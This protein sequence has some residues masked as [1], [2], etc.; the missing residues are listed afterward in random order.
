[1]RFELS[2]RTL[3]FLLT[4]LAVLDGGNVARSAEEEFNP[5]RAKKTNDEIL[6]IVFQEPFAEELDPP[7]IPP[8][9]ALPNDL[10]PEDYSPDSLRNQVDAQSDWSAESEQE[11]LYWPDETY[12]HDPNITRG[13]IRHHIAKLRQ[14]IAGFTGI[15]LDQSGRYVGLGQPLTDTSWLNRPW[16]FGAFL[17]TQTHDDLI[18]GQLG[19]SNSAVGGARLGLDFS[20]YWGLEGRFAYSNPDTFIPGIPLVIGNS[21]NYYVDLN[22]MYYP[23]G[24]SRWRPYFSVGLGASTYRFN[25][26]A[27]SIAVSDSGLRVP[28]AVGLKYFYSPWFTFR[29]D[30]QLSPTFTTE[31]FDQQ[32][33][34][35][36]SMGAE[37]RFGGK[38]QSYFPW[39][40]GTAYW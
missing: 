36:L 38:K 16:S 22:L 35:M 26:T 1:M 31:N 17:G 27:T 33:E 2:F 9:S 3:F 23:W 19:Q 39:H 34:F 14:I 30:A 24:D 25:D 29:F 11:S 20:P 32:T 15:G 13:P 37:I 12:A 4:A 10:P 40:S 5:L 21:H 18:S 7:P 6:P 28:L 8:D